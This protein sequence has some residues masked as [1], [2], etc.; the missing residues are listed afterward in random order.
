MPKNSLEVITTQAKSM[1]HTL[2]FAHIG[3]VSH[4][5]LNPDH[6]IPRF[7]KE[8]QFQIQRNLAYMQAEDAASLSRMQ[9]VLASAFGTP[10]DWTLDELFDA[11]DYFAP[12][13]ARFGAHETDGACF[14]FWESIDLAREDC[15]FVSSRKREYPADDFVGYWL[16]V[17]DHGNATLY[18]RS[19]GKDTE[20]WSV[21]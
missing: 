6:L 4:A 21:V 11:L 1:K 5:T 12:P 15:E 17:S 13:F 7:A 9:E 10:D 18:E 14:G 8:L 19:E 16:H 3:S 20:I 2:K